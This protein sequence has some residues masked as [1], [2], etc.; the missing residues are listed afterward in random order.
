M[1]NHN[2]SIVITGGSGFIGTHVVD[3]LQSRGFHNITVVDLKPPQQTAVQFV[4]ASILD[5]PAIK[6]IIAGADYVFHF[7]AMVGVDACRTQPSKVE[8]L[9]YHASKNVIDIAVDSGVKKI[10]FSS[11]SEV[12][13]NA[14]EVP[15]IEGARPAPISLYSKYKVAIEDYLRHTSQ[16]HPIASGVA[17]LF[18]AYGPGQRD[19]FVV[20]VFVREALR[21]NPLV[22]HGDGTQTRSF[23]FINDIS[24]GLVDL[25]L[26]DHAPY[27]VVNLGNPSTETSIADLARLVISLIPRSAST[28]QFK[29]YGTENIREFGLEIQRR[30]PSIEKAKRLLGFT[31]MIGLKEGIQ[32][33][34]AYQ[35]Y[36][37]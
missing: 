29:N 34:I 26:C 3:E 22:I 18:N 36:G 17:R 5:I 13:G 37:R 7:A 16:G 32:Q 20:G 12:Y 35:S 21:D 30:V 27:E 15:H 19:D 6:P 10:I 2:D 9:N 1:A 31:P 11:S 24:R 28:I 33:V 4:R 14:I 23:T 25:F 8:E